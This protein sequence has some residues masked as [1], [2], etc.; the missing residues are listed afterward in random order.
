MKAIITGAAALSVAV[1]LAL[2]AATAQA[3]RGGKDDARTRGLF[4]SKRSDAMRIVVSDARDLNNPVPVD[5]NREF[6]EGDELK[7]YLWSNFTGFVYIVNIQPSGKKCLLFPSAEMADNAIAPGRRYEFP[8]G[9]SV[10]AFD[11]EKGTE[12]LQVITSRERIQYLDKA[13]N[14]PEGCLGESAA[15]AASE[16]AEDKNKPAKTEQGGIVV[17]EVASVLPSTGPGA[18]RS[19]DI[20]LAPGKDKD[21]EGSVV[22]ISDSKGKDGKLKPGEAGVFEIRLK[23]N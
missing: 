7:V 8:P 15:S 21:P 18:M 22:A 11:K 1:A 10:I 3:K 14:N 9:P 20:I 4:V 12:V 19:R 2:P 13:I 5:P 16:L 6:K 23:H 17:G